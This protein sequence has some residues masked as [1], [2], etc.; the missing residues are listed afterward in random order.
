[1]VSILVV[2]DEANICEYVRAVLR[3]AGFSVSTAK[4]GKEALDEIDSG[5][6]ALVVTDLIMPEHDGLEL[7]A[8]LKK[9]RNAIRIIAMSGGGY[10]SADHYLDIAKGFMVD[11]ILAKPFMPAELVAMVTEVLAGGR[12]PQF[13]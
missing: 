2:D 5:K 3:G 10:L 6:H 4:D 1:M 12:A 8:R 7:I 9:Q 11:R 13:S